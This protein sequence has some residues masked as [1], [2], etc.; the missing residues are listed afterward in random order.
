[1]GR[2]RPRQANS[3][4]PASEAAAHGRMGMGMPDAF[5]DVQL[6]W[7]CLRPCPMLLKMNAVRRFVTEGLRFPTL[8]RVQCSHMKAAVRAPLWVVGCETCG[9]IDKRLECIGHK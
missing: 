4:S 1:M 3:G 2:A 5:T 8:S 7:R 9:V 6:L